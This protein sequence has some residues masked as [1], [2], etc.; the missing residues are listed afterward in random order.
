MT[1]SK[2]LELLKQGKELTRTNRNG[3]NQYVFLLKG[4]NIESAYSLKS[5]GKIE[6]ND[7][8]AI[9]TTSNQIQLGWLASQ[10]DMLSDDWEVVDSNE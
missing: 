2:A 8:L 5:S 1:F 7:T 9:R 4:A 3:K 6:V 10:T